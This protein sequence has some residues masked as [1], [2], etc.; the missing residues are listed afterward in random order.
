LT[1][2]PLSELSRRLGAA[3]HGDPNSVVTGFATDSGSVQH[4]D[5]FLAFKGS[6]VDGHDFAADALAKGAVAALVSRPIDGPHLL[7][8]DVVEALADMAASYRRE[9]IG[10]VVAITGSAGK[11]T[12][13]EFVASAL[14]PL[15]SILKSQGNRNSEYT[16]PLVWNDLLPSHKAVV[17]EMAMRGFGQIRHLASF[18]RPT[19][20]LVTNVGYAHQEMVGSRA[21][22]ADAK[23]ELLELLPPDGLAIIWNEDEF[24][25]RLVA[26]SAAPVKTFGFLDGADSRVTSYRAVDWDA[27]EV[28]GVTNGCEWNT[29]LPAIGKHMALNAAAAMLVADT[30]GVAL[31]EASEALRSVSLPPMRMQ[32]IERKGVRILLDNY[33]ASPPSMIAAIEALSEIPISG[34]RL[35]VIGEMRE[36]GSDTEEGH[37]AVGRSLAASEIDAAILVGEATKFVHA[38]AI[39]AKNNLIRASDFEEVRAFL[40]SALPG[41]AILIKGSRALELE[42]AL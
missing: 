24:R 13:K 1:P 25:D 3:F 4:G 5:L 8:S 20:G 30:C 17:V 22:I 39:E 35:A 36:L 19:I 16:S 27:S 40:D 14:S 12:T 38:E 15:G 28:S 26:K 33:N 9:F 10:P 18:A 31:G 37:R 34:K 21:G 11:T 42:K 6:R 32:V 7:V 2:T 29:R 41:D 23:G